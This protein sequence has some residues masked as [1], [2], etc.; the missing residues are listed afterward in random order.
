MATDSG[1]VHF[2]DAV[3][4]PA[5]DHV[6]SDTEEIDLPDL[7][8]EPIEGC[9]EEDVGQMRVPARSI[10]TKLYTLFDGHEI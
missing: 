2:V 3:W 10:C 6:D 7:T 9:R 1:W 4:T 5:L 8:F